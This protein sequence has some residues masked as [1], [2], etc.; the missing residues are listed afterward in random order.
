MEHHELPSSEFSGNQVHSVID[1]QTPWVEESQHISENQVTGVCTSLSGTRAQNP[2]HHGGSTFPQLGEG[3]FD[4]Q[5]VEAS[6]F[7]LAPLLQVSQFFTSIIFSESVLSKILCL[8]Q[9][10]ISQR[11]K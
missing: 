5:N 3:I 11:P 9:A 1:W 10:L 8:Q 6:F 7:A 4:D 2:R